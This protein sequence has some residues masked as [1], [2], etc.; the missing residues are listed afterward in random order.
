MKK[1]TALRVH[2]SP[3]EGNLLAAL[4][5]Q[6]RQVRQGIRVAEGFFVSPDKIK[7]RY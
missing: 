4:V 7:S 3:T 5:H 2:Q 1:R 6:V